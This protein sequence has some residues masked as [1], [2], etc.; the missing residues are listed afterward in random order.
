MQ[1]CYLQLRAFPLQDDLAQILSYLLP[2]PAHLLL[3]LQ[4]CS[5]WTGVGRSAAQGNTCLLGLGEE[6]KPPGTAV[7]LFLVPQCHLLF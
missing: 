3:A 2:Q 7:P 5:L 1:G 6:A 4:P